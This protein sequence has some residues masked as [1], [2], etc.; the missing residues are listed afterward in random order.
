MQLSPLARRVANRSANTSL[1]R[2]VPAKHPRISVAALVKPFGA[3]MTLRIGAIE[4]LVPA[5]KLRVVGVG[6][7]LGDCP[8][9]EPI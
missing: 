5:G 9:I 6:Q 4:D 2:L 3:A 7:A 1:S 8:C